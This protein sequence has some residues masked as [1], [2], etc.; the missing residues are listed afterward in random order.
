LLDNLISIKT[1]LKDCM[2]IRRVW[3]YQRGNQNPYFEEE[4]TTQ[5]LKE[6]VQKDK[7]RSTKHTYASKL[8][9]PWWGIFQ[10]T[11]NL[12]VSQPNT[13]INMLIEM[14]FQKLMKQRLSRS[15]RWWG[16][17][18]VWRRQNVTFY[19]ME[20]KGVNLLIVVQCLCAFDLCSLRKL[21][22]A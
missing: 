12:T 4:Q 11:F 20:T 1:G 19:T 6:K 7:Q 10:V 2:S 13:R 9:I 8:M 18:Q 22:H 21:T 14:L 17:I 16:K 15:S 3:R 5:W